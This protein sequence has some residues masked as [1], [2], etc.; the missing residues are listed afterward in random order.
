MEHSRTSS[1]VETR[2]T[3][4]L[5]NDDYIYNYISNINNN[6]NNSNTELKIR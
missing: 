3:V 5:R 6:Y 4:E 1:N 2:D